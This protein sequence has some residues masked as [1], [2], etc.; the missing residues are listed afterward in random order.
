MRKSKFLIVV[1]VSLLGG[2]QLVGCNTLF[3]SKV[4]DGW[5]S[6][7]SQNIKDV[8]DQMVVYL[9]RGSG[10]GSDLL[11]PCVLYSVVVEET[12][13][14]SSRGGDAPMNKR[15]LLAIRVAERESHSCYKQAF[16]TYGGLAGVVRAA[17]CVDSSFTDSEVYLGMLSAALE[18][19][20]VS[21]FKFSR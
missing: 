14:W 15:L 3:S 6:A 16:T 18:L 10:D 9:G 5:N 7:N 11:R 21:V 17:A 12:S 13:F 1:I 4:P 2:L 19:N 8:S 20:V